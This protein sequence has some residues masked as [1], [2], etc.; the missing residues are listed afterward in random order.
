[1]TAPDLLRW[2]RAHRLDAESRDVD[3]PDSGAYWTGIVYPSVELFPGG[4][5]TSYT[6]AA[7]ILAADAISGASPAADLFGPRST[8]D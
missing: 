7:V 8:L 2:T 3:S 6:A 5:H 1:M 4:E